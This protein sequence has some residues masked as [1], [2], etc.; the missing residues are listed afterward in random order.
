MIR[1]GICDD[2]MYTTSQLENILTEYAR[3]LGIII[4]IDV[5]YDG[6]ELLRYIETQQ[7][8]YDLIFLDIR[9]KKMNGMEVARKIRET[10]QI[11]IL[12]FVTSYKSYALEAYEVHPYQF[13]IKPIIPRIVKK[14]FKQVYD[15]ITAN[16]FYYEF[17]SNKDYYRILLSD[18]MYFQ[19]QKRL[20]YIHMNDG[21][22]LKYYDKINCIQEKLADTKADFWRI[23]HSIL[24]NSKYV[25]RKAF[26]HIELVNGEI[27]TISEDKR[28]NF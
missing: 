7:P 17:K 22:I 12:I 23:H 19:S 13:I 9:M 28:K 25:K 2:E 1:I 5:F 24:V 16:A 3:E 21:E 10:N 8:D 4:D 6:E 15:I 11:V 14:Y 20:I 26:N 27:L 18:I